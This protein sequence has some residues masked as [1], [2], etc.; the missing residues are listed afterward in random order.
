MTSINNKPESP[1]SLI[2]IIAGK[3]RDLIYRDG[4]DDAVSMSDKSGSRA[5]TSTFDPLELSELFC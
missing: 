5:E 2:Q 1:S 4:T 3:C